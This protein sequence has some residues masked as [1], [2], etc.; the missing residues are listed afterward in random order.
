MPEGL[1]EMDEE[2]M[3]RHMEFLLEWQAQFA[4]ELGELKESN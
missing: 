4:A 1:T 3:Q 2:K